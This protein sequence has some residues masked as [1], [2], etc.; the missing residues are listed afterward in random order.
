MVWTQL[1]YDNLLQVLRWLLPHNSHW[2]LAKLWIWHTYHG[3][4]DTVD[5]VEDTLD[6]CRRQRYSGFLNDILDPTNDEDGSFLVHERPISR[7][8]PNSMLIFIES[9]RLFTVQISGNV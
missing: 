8:K 2:H 6:K 9:F 1:I 4:F 3:C 7:P 5:S